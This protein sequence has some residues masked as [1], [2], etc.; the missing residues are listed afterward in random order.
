MNFY[1]SVTGIVDDNVEGDAVQ[2]AVVAS[3][4]PF[5]DLD[6]KVQSKVTTQL[7]PPSLDE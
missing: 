4:V 3:L 2:S 5:S 7:D 6:L 1:L